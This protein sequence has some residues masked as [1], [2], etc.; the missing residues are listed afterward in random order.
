M[1]SLLIQQLILACIV[2]IWGPPIVLAI[3]AGCGEP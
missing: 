1:T 3:I 2:G